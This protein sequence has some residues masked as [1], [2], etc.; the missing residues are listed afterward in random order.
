M[1]SEAFGEFEYAI[2][3][4]RRLAALVWPGKNLGNIRG[5]GRFL[6]NLLSGISFNAC[7]SVPAR[8]LMSIVSQLLT[9]ESSGE[10]RCR[11]LEGENSMPRVA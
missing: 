2:L 5:E 7:T 10:Q 11:F 8:A 4:S 6:V 3:D 9:K 1:H